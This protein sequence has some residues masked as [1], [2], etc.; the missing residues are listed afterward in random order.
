M[1]YD[2]EEFLLTAKAAS[3]RYELNAFLCKKATTRSIEADFERDAS[4]Y[5]PRTFQIPNHFYG[6]TY[7]V[8]PQ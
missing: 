7:R 2:R 4:S 6:S 8:P 3:L 5:E 1:L